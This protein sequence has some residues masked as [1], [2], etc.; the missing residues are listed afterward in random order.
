METLDGY[1]VEEL[2][3]RQAARL[4]RKRIARRSEPEASEHALGQ[5]LRNQA[6]GREPNRPGRS[7]D[8]TGGSQQKDGEVEASDE[9][10]ERVLT[11]WCSTPV[12][13]M[14]KPET[15]RGRLGAFLRG[16]LRG[17]RLVADGVLVPRVLSPLS[18]LGP[19]GQRA[20]YAPLTQLRLSLD[21]P[22]GR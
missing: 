8:R 14:P 2:T 9:K 11:D 3:P 17:W 18:Q 21:P 22:Y 19:S 20:G 1:E 7:P 12:A 15:K 16:R 5:S 4:L 10:E 13:A 6:R